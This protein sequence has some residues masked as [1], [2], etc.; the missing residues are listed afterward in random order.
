MKHISLIQ[1]K[2]GQKGRIA[3]IQGGHDLANRLDTMGLRIGSSL[4]KISHSFLR[5]PVTVNVGAT[6]LSL[7]FGMALKVIVETAEPEK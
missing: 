2:Q 3:E 1:M 4:T 7:G 6:Q 5:G